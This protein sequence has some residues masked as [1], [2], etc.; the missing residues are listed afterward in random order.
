[1]IG[2]SHILKGKRNGPSDSEKGKELNLSMW[3][4]LTAEA[5]KK[6]ANSLLQLCTWIDIWSLATYMIKTNRTR[7][8]AIW[9][10]DTKNPT[11]L[12]SEA[13]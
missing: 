12:T 3:Q 2:P 9:A 6:D 4:K 5:E 13:W 10:N 7:G 1:M 11:R 8:N